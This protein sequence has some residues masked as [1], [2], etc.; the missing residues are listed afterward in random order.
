MLG[1]AGSETESQVLGVGDGFREERSNVFVVQRVDHLAPV[2]IANNESEVTQNTQL[3]GHSRL[4]HLDLPRKLSH[5]ARTGAEST[6]DSHPAGGRER[7]HR[8]S[9]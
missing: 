7:L 9:D 6:E 4:L 8:L 2:P 1:G 5:R 3:L